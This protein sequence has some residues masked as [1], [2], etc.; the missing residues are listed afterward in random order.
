MMLRRSILAITFA[1]LP[2]IGCKT[3]TV[4]KEE[5]V[6]MWQM[7]AGDRVA[8]RITGSIPSLSLR[9]NGTF[10]ATSL[11]FDLVREDALQPD[12]SVSGSGTWSIEQTDDNTARV[13]LNLW[14]VHTNAGR[15][16]PSYGTQLFLEGSGSSIRLYYS[17]GDPDEKQRIHFEHVSSI[18]S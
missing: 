5:L 9:S 18:P 7:K 1:S 2:I 13:Q 17:Q 3:N 16:L 15:G 14:T 8:A 12:Q 6:G 4:T 10:A 11:P